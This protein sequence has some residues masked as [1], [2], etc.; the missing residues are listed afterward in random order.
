MSGDSEVA[1]SYH[2]GIVQGTNYTGGIA[3]LM[4]NATLR[5]SYSSSTISGYYVAGGLIGES[6][7]ANIYDSYSYSNV[8]GIQ[9]TG[10]LIGDSLQSTSLERS[11]NSGEVTGFNI[12][13]GL[14]GSVTQTNITNSNNNGAVNGS[15]YVGGLFG[16]VSNITTSNNYVSSIVSGVNNVGAVAGSWAGS[17]TNVLFNTD[18]MLSD[19]SGSTGKS[20]AQLKNNFTYAGWD[21]D[22][23][24]ELREGNFPTLK[25][26]PYEVQ[27]DVAPP[28]LMNAM[29]A[30]SAPSIIKLTFDEWVSVDHVAGLVVT[31]DGEQVPV[32]SIEKMDDNTVQLV[33]EH[34]IA[35]TATILIF[36]DQEL[37]TIKDRAGNSL[38]TLTAYEVNV[39]LNVVFHSNDGKSA[40]IA[41]V[42][43]NSLATQP[44]E[45]YR[46]GYTFNGWY[47][48]NG[49][50]SL[51]F[52][53]SSTPVEDNLN[54][55]A[56]W[57]KSSPILTINYSHGVI[58]GTQSHL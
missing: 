17:P 5:N 46:E 51:P 42:L 32:D 29:L 6:S 58:T 13:G 30:S 18:H 48:D 2:T 47:S 49:M 54:L 36:N 56:Q 38:P 9:N 23:I 16:D 24:W 53:F 31:V 43:R 35:F 19:Q 3:G 34:S 20:T 22:N 27:K 1:N 14:I 21:L 50:F 52:D 57:I 7:K 40:T 39:E 37:T 8:R 12:V 4:S 15:S 11:F 25:G 45:H 41:T 33:L 26:M 44:A 10:G 55:Y 28:I